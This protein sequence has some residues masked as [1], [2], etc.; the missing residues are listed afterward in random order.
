MV[1]SY[2]GSRHG[3]G[4][5]DGA[6]EILKQKIREEQLNMDA[7]RFQSVADVVS[8]CERKQMEK[9]LT[10]PDVRRQVSHFFHLV[11]LEDV[12]KS[13]LWDYNNIA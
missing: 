13:T 3:K 6:R 12:D 2:F 7:R 10:Y 4:V 9:H 11:K 8:F 1:W 5:H